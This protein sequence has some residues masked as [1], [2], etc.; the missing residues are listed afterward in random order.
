MGRAFD[1]TATQALR[2]PSFAQHYNELNRK[3]RQAL[4]YRLRACS[5]VWQAGAGRP[6][7]SRDGLHCARPRPLAL[8][9]RGGGGRPQRADHCRLS[10]GAD[11]IGT[12]DRRPTLM[13]SGD[14]I[15]T[16]YGVTAAVKFQRG[17]GACPA[18]TRADGFSGACA[19]VRVLS[20]VGLA[21]RLAC[22][23][24]AKARSKL[25]MR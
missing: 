4:G 25:R 7:R 17:A 22:A 1:Q 18:L 9:P 23:M 19:T 2:S 11:W 6:E 8:L 15:C 12:C 3:H 14:N 24:S 13:I 20:L 10:Q 16:R 5:I 21:R